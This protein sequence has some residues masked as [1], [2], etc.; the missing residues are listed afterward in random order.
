MQGVKKGK[1]TFFL[2]TTYEEGERW[3]PGYLGTLLA[4]FTSFYGL[5]SS[6]SIIIIIVIIAVI[7]M[8]IIFMRLTEKWCPEGQYFKMGFDLKV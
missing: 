8:V 3:V 5:T 6:E 7:V 4:L 2:S 1:K